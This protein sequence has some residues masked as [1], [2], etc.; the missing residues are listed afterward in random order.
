M[1][2]YARGK[3]LPRGIHATRIENGVSAGFPDVHYSHKGR[4]GTIELKFLRKKNPP[5][6]DDGLNIDQIHWIEDELKAGGRVWILADIGKEICLIRGKHFDQFNQ[7]KRA[8]FEDKS[9]IIFRKRRITR[10][11]LEDL[12][13]FL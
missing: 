4:S 13:V 2:T 1:W 3:L 10:D 12:D 8:D 11:K 9:T 6:G 5:F 7:W